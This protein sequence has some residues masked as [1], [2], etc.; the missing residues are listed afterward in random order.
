MDEVKKWYIVAV[1]GLIVCIAAMLGVQLNTVEYSTRVLTARAQINGFMGALDAY[2]SD[3]GGYPS[4]E[5]GLAALRIRPRSVPD[6]QGP[7]L[8]S[9]IPR[10]PWGREYI[11]NFP[12][13]HGPGPDIV[14]YGADG[15][16]GG[17]GEN[18]DSWGWK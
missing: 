11:Y 13:A 7:Y 17:K 18:S 5:E 1:L 9:D 6:W 15:R 2:K 12:G 8:R 16:P 10:D 3:T 4:T 14:S